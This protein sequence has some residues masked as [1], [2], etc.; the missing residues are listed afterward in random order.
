MAIIHQAQLHPTKMEL[1]ERWLPLQSWYAGGSAALSKVGSFRFDDPSGEVGIETI[2]TAVDGAVFQVPL[3]Y[4][5]APLPD[6]ES[7]LIGTMQHSVLGERWVYDACGDP[8]Y[9]AAIAAAI[10]AGAPQAEQYLDVEGRLEALPQ[11]VIVHSTGQP[12]SVPPVVGPVTARDTDV[13]TVVRAGE[14]ELLVSRRLQ[15]EDGQAVAH[16]LAG[17]W[18]GQ[19]APVTLAA[20]TGR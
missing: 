11:S 10:L 16:A 17:T 19:D 8:S 4:R 15:L 5:G 20:V 3:T 2:L 1:L 18:A 14:L 13:G 7:S 9:A 6:A 12:G